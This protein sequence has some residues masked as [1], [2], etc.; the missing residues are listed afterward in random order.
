M[1]KSDIADILTVTAEAIHLNNALTKLHV[2]DV[3]I[4]N[5]K[6]IAIINCLTSLRELCMS[7]CSFTD[8]V[9]MIAE[10]IKCNTSL[11]KLDISDSTI[12]ED[13][14]E[15]I[16]SNCLKHNSTLQELGMVNIDITDKGASLIAE[17]IQVNVTL[18]MLDTSKNKITDFGAVAI[19]AS[20]KYNKNL[21]DLIVVHNHKVTVVGILYLTKCLKDTTLVKVKMVSEER[22]QFICDY[23]KT[24]C[25]PLDRLHVYYN[26]SENLLTILELNQ[27]PQHKH[28]TA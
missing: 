18:L 1:P 22:K 4:C 23:L 27:R 9:K 7:M 14:V 5:D 2:H 19:S 17:G 24:D 11:R 8:S 6:S 25:S 10:A 13:N 16:I 3:Y 12:S 26:T 15:P 20:L 21:Q 28:G